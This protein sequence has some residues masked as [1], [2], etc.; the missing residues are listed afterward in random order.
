MCDST[1]GN[2]MSLNLPPSLTNG[3][4]RALLVAPTPDGTWIRTLTLPIPPFPGLGVRLDTYE[5]VNVDTVLVGDDHRWE[6]D[7][8]CIVSPDGGGTYDEKKWTRLG[9]EQGIYV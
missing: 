8:T 9:F 7:V 5:V 3:P 6:I 2:T 1:K 4:I